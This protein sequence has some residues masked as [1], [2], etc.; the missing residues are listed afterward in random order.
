MVTS[1]LGAETGGRFRPLTGK[2]GPCRAGAGRAETGPA[3]Q[4]LPSG[5]QLPVQAVTF[6]RLGTHTQLGSP[7]TGWQ[8]HLSY[9]CVTRLVRPPGSGAHTGSPTALSPLPVAGSQ[10]GDVGGAW[11]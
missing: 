6:G 7:C 2:S 4:D 5:A 10:G 8:A 11:G 9:C 1:P 3:A